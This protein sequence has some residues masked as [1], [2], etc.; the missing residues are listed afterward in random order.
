MLALLSRDEKSK[1]P[2]TV[3]SGITCGWKHI[4]GSTDGILVR[5]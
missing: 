3:K 4:G 5:L 2:V 1:S